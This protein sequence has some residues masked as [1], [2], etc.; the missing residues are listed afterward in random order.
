M[1]LVEGFQPMPGEEPAK[2]VGTNPIDIAKP[3][4]RVVIDYEAGTVYSGNLP[5]CAVEDCLDPWVGPPITAY[6]SYDG[7]SEHGLAL[8]P[9]PKLR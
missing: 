3:V 9:R 4:G 6:G 7:Y 2:V 1:N 8:G 5:Y